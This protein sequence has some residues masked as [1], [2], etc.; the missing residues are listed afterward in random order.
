MLFIGIGYIDDFGNYYSQIE[1]ISV[2]L[3]EK[4]T[5]MFDSKWGEQAGDWEWLKKE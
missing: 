5:I 2:V 4:R 1:K 3:K